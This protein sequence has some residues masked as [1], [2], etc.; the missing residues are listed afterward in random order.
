M[1]RYN[2]KEELLTA[3]SGVLMRAN[4]KGN[5]EFEMVVEVFKRTIEREKAGAPKVTYWQ[6]DELLK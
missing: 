3:L 2:S 4:T 1:E 5:R 6:P